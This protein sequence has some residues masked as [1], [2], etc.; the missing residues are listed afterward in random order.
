MNA[1]ARMLVAGTA[2][3]ALSSMSIGLVPIGAPQSR[4]ASVWA[5]DSLPEHAA[6]V[7]LS[8]ISNAETRLTTATVKTRDG[9]NLGSVHTVT[10]GADGKIKTVQ[11][12]VVQAPAMQGGIVVLDARG[13][14]YLADDN[15]IQTSLT[16]RQVENLPRVQS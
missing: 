10:R 13:L 2:L 11:V 8:D 6:G 1:R 5:A 7:S 9:E 3:L 12:N 4:I 16:R 14:V 15:V